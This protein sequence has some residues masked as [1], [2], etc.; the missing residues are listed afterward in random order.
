MKNVVK[1]G[2]FVAVVTPNRLR[3]GN[4]QR[5]FLGLKPKLMSPMHFR[6]YS[7][8]ELIEMGGT[9]GLT[10]AGAFGE[11]IYDPIV[12]LPIHLSLKLGLCL[13]PIAHVIG[14]VFRT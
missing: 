3:W 12:R 10:F 2:G 5:R 14:V 6:E 4:V 7:R 11:E 9:V 1:P 13:M 8:A